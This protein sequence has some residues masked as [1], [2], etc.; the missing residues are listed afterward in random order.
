VVPEVFYEF[1]RQAL[2]PRDAA[3][4]LGVSEAQLRQA[5]LRLDP[6]QGSDSERSIKR[7]LRRLDSDAGVVTRE[8]FTSGYALLSCAIDG[9]RNRSARC[10]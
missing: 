8:A 1:R 6:E 10:P 9:V 4:E 7:T 5:L 2:G 3:A